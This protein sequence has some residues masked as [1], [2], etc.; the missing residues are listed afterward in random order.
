MRAYSQILLSEVRLQL[1]PQ[2]KLGK[3]L[4]GQDLHLLIQKEEPSSIPQL[5]I[6]SS[7]SDAAHPE[8]RQ[9]VTEELQCTNSSSV[10]LGFSLRLFSLI[11]ILTASRHWDKTS[12]TS[13]A[14]PRV[15][16]YHWV[17]SAYWWYQIPNGQMTSQQLH[18]GV[19]NGRREFNP[20]IS[21][22]GAAIR[23]THTPPTGMGCWR[24]SGT[25]VKRGLQPPISAASPEGYHSQCYWRPLRGALSS[26][27]GHQQKWPMPS[28]SY[29][30][31][32]TL[33]FSLFPYPMTL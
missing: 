33:T 27:T 1:V 31:V 11:Q 10:L 4:P 20:V 21:H 15:T 18:T 19:N 29:T 13:P 7:W 3:D 23:L 9:E 2:L 32:W 25:T 16:M 28:L 24:R 30:Q 6:C 22:R 5:R 14:Q 26:S 12:T 8:A 17:A